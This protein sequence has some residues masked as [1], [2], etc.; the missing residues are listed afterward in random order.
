[1]VIRIDYLAISEQ[2]VISNDAS[3][4]ALWSGFR[5]FICDYLPVSVIDF[6]ARSIS[7]VPVGFPA[8]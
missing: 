4:D 7:A 2:V 8:R 1:M 6:S 5:N 3:D